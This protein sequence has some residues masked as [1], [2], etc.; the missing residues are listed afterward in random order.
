MEKSAKPTM[1]TKLGSFFFAFAIFLLPRRHHWAVALALFLPL[2]WT[3]ATIDAHDRK[4]E[5]LDRQIEKLEDEYRGQHSINRACLERH[6][7]A[8]A[9]LKQDHK[10]QLEQRHAP[11][12]A[13]ETVCSRVH[14]E[15]RDRD[16][17]A[18]LEIKELKDIISALQQ[19]NPRQE[20][21]VDQR[22][23]SATPQSRPTTW[24]SL[25][26]KT[27]QEEPPIPVAAENAPYTSVH[28]EVRDAL[29][30]AFEREIEDLKDTILKLR[31]E[32]AHPPVAFTTGT[33]RTRVHYEGSYDQESERE[34]EELRKTILKLQHE[35][36]QYEQAHAP[37]ASATAEIPC[38]RVHYEGG[39]DEVTE[40]EN[41][42]LK[43]AN[44]DL[45]AQISQMHRRECLWKNRVER[46]EIRAE[47]FQQ[48]AINL[49]G[50]LAK[51]QRGG[52]SNAAA[53]T[54][55]TRAHC[56]DHD[57]EAD[58][59]TNQ[60]LKPSLTACLTRS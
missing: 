16:E 43:E 4:T 49:Q 19:E 44:A 7:E 10:L 1:G 47:K 22:S 30:L 34:K 23:P 28:H 11:I 42:E 45:R 5:K 20:A 14:Y 55:C 53:E 27:M 15:D 9:K 56:E 58:I 26:K 52:P 18:E 41:K 48:D 13:D 51:H 2:L 32:K 50:T 59:K 33:S 39:R 31:Q 36:P 40:R 24:R 17:V 8:I 38:T 60:E 54:P 35:K 3:L 21:E 29:R 25:G 57:S 46:R 6:Q 12:I 37:V